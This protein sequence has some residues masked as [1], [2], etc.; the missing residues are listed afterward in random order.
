MELAEE[1]NGCGDPPL[2]LGAPL[3]PMLS[4]DRIIRDEEMIRVRI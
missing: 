2:L 1:E 4:F 3:P